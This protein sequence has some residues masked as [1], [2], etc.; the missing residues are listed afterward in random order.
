MFSIT[1]TAAARDA[2][3][4]DEVIFFE[5]HGIGVCCAH[6]GEFSARPVRRARLPRRARQLGDDPAFALPVAW[7]HLAGHAVTIDCHT[8]GR[9]RRFT[10]DLPCLGGTVR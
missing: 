6:D 3:R 1:L 2:L 7:M 5:W 9:W 4:P 10:T 8:W